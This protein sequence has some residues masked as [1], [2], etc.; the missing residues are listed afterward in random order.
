MPRVFFKD[1]TGPIA[2]AI[3]VATEHDVCDDFQHVDVD[4]VAGPDT[5]FMNAGVVELLPERPS[6]RHVFDYVQKS[7]FL[8][9]LPIALLVERKKD[10]INAAWLEADSGFFVYDSKQIACDQ[11]SRKRIE[12]VNGHVS[13]FDSMPPSW[14][15][16]W[17]AEDNTYVAVA[18]VPSWKRFYSAMV[19][20]GMDNFA[21][22]QRLKAELGRAATPEQVAAVVW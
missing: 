17:K 7:W 16:Q 12:T 2:W 19:S 20:Q 11:E 4:V 13:L 3:A 5:H 8:P 9:E 21:K 10:E 18:D 6:V 14:P 22:A 1:P 15:G